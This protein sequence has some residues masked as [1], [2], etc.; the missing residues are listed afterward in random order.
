MSTYKLATG[1]VGSAATLLYVTAQPEPYNRNSYHL[2]FMPKDTYICVNRERIS[3]SKSRFS[4]Y[5]GSLMYQRKIVYFW[6]TGVVECMNQS[7]CDPV[8]SFSMDMSAGDWVESQTKELK[9][10]GIEG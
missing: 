4:A 2:F 3:L 5:S 6:K 8:D 10:L 7:G 1:V 9:E